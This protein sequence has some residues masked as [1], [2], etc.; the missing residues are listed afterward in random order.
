MAPF[1]G[2][3]TPAATASLGDAAKIL[4][5]AWGLSIPAAIALRSLLLKGGEVPPLGFT[6][7]AMIFTFVALLSWRGLYTVVNPTPEGD[8]EA[9]V[10]D[11]FRMITTLVQ[12]W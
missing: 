10:L 3:H 4:L 1:L 12:R 8:K 5:P 7:A 2:A 11:V 9:S 6:V